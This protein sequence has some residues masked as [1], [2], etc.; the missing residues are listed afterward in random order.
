MSILLLYSNERNCGRFKQKLRILLHEIFACRLFLLS[1]AFSCFGV[2]LFR[3]IC[4][5]LRLLIYFSLRSFLKEIKQTHVI[6]MLSVCAPLS[7]LERILFTK[8]NTNVMTIGSHAKQHDVLQFP[9]VTNS[10][11]V[12]TQICEMETSVAKLTTVP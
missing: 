8:C 5:S 11:I 4:L 2:Y 1:L 9:A 6:V 7:S 12:N 3:I 10:N